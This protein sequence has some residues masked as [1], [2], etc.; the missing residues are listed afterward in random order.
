MV[1]A[2]ADRRRR[3][4]RR[5]GAIT[6]RV[7]VRGREAHVGQAHLGVNAFEHMLADRRAADEARA[8]AAQQREP[9]GATPARCSSS[10][11]AARRE[12]QRRARRGLVLRRPPLQP[13]GAARRRARAADR[14]H[15]RGR[16]GGRRRRQDRRAASPA[17]G[18]HRPRTRPPGAG[19]LRRRRS[20][21]PPSFELCPGTLDTRW[22]AQL[23]IPAFGYG[24]GRL[25]V[26]HG[27]DEYIDEAAMRRCAAVYTLAA[28]ELLR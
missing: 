21:A 6:L 5:R 19:A 24:A 18:G 20:R 12:L 7:A 4:A 26:S 27:P 15:R 10:A 2:G 14:H 9:R 13:R 1:T 25:D 11:A 28:S 23:G 8:R 16:R 22:Y 17:L 3:V